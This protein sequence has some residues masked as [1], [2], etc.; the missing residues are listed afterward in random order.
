MLNLWAMEEASLRTLLE[1]VE[2][3]T[4]EEL[5]AANAAQYP[6]RIA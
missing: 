6:G 1:K 3:A 2:N 5:A 4:A